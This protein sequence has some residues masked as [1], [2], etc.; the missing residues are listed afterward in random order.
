M[1]VPMLDLHAQYSLMKN[2]ISEAI[3]TVMETQQFRGGPVVEAFEKAVANYVNADFALGVATGTDAL[4]LLMR[5]I[6][7]KPGDEVITTPFSFFA[8]AGAIVNAGGVPVFVD[9]EPDTYN[10]N[11]RLVESHITPRTRALLPVHLFGQCAD[12]S[13]LLNLGE[14]HNLPVIEDAAQAL[15]ASYHERMACSLGYAAALSFYPTKNLGAAGEGGMIITKDASLAQKIKLLRSHGADR[16]YHHQLVGTNSHLHAIQAAILSVKLRY[17]NKWN[18][19]RQAIAARYN[20]KLAQYDEI[21]RPSVR[22]GNVHCY[23]QY[24]IRIPER[25]R[26]VTLFK[27]RGVGCGVYYPIP[28]HR[29]ECFVPLNFA[30]S[31]CLVADQASKEVL[32]LPIYPELTEEQQDEVFAA[33]EHHLATV[34]KK[35][36]TF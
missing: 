20:D 29:Q 28:L 34:K 15:G 23:H 25:D 16:T 4:L 3:S 19:Q 21:T 9:I 36:T 12:M 22:E 10:I 1:P 13:T 27:E 18:A 32:A 2:E 17:L 24:V 5:A 6:N 7:L 14:K 30:T 8:T 33:L 26:A 11:T 35:S 31:H